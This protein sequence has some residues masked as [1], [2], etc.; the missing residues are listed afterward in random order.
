MALDQIILDSLLQNLE[1]VFLNLND[2]THDIIALS[3]LFSW[4][5]E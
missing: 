1:T 5:F 4:L 3:R 2:A